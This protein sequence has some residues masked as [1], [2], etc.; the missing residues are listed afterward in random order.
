MNRADWN[1]ILIKMVCKQR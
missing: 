1:K